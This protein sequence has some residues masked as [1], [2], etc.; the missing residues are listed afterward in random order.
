MRGRCRLEGVMS[1]LHSFSV[2]QSVTILSENTAEI[3]LLRDPFLFA[4]IPRCLRCCID[5]EFNPSTIN[6]E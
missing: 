3:E 5:F 6:L 1:L 4:I 2:V